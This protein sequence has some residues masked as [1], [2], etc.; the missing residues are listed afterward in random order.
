M[1]TPGSLG[2]CRELSQAGGT[3]L[4]G[5]GPGAQPKVAPRHR[6]H[7]SHCRPDSHGASKTGGPG[8]GGR[9]PR[10]PRGQTAK[11]VR[12]ASAR[13]LPQGQGSPL[14]SPTWS[15]DSLGGLTTRLSTLLSQLRPEGLAGPSPSVQ[16]AD[17]GEPCGGQASPGRLPLV[18]H[19]AAEGRALA[20]S[21][22][23]P[24]AWTP[25]EESL[26]GHTGHAGQCSTPH[27]G[28]SACHLVTPLPWHYVLLE[29]RPPTRP[30]KG[31]LC[32]PPRHGRAHGRPSWPS[33]L[34]QSKV[35]GTQTRVQCSCWGEVGQRPVPRETRPTRPQS[36]CTGARGAPA[37][38]WAKTGPLRDS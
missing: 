17:S 10:G 4:Q 8:G 31:Q 12:V 11:C 25:H 21:R 14:C 32:A 1:G 5:R 27:K 6:G 37:H 19:G 18:T 2:T 34:T 38:S 35:L 15:S 7:P 29:R 13:S 36:R 3:P 30:V 28:T 22:R 33:V 9:T 16:G 26:C 24:R 20:Q 23:R